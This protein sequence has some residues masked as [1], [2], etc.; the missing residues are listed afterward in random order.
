MHDHSASIDDVRTNAPAGSSGATCWSREF[1]EVERQQVGDIGI[2]CAL[3]QF[4]EYMQEVRVR[5][6]VAGRPPDAC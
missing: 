2:R 4:G 3:R 1:R 6:D 5:L